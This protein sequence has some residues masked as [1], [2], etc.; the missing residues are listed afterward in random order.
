MSKLFSLNGIGHF[1]T[2]NIIRS[3]WQI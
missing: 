3:L 1:E 2:P